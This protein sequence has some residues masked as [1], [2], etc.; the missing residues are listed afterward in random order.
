MGSRRQKRKLYLGKNYKKLTLRNYK[1]YYCYKIVTVITLNDNQESI[2]IIK[3]IL[4]SLFI[5]TGISQI[6]SMNNISYNLRNNENFLAQQK[7]WL[8]DNPI[9]CKKFEDGL[10]ELTQNNYRDILK[11]NLD[12]WA[13]SNSKKRKYQK[14]VKPQPK[15]KKDLKEQLQEWIGITPNALYLLSNALINNNLYQILRKM[16]RFNFSLD[17]I[18]KFNQIIIQLFSPKT[19]KNEDLKTFHESSLNGEV[20]I[21]RKFLQKGFRP[22]WLISPLLASGLTIAAVSKSREITEMFFECSKINHAATDIYGHTALM[23]SIIE[24]DEPVIRL[25]LQ[26]KD[27]WNIHQTNIFGQ[28]I[29]DLAKENI[30][31]LMHILTDYLEN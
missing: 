16:H 1:H 10:R 26:K 11:L 19:I 15:N 23:R 21:V 5:S 17:D 20:Q 30:P 29:F 22:N 4:T 8:T 9:E 31:H 28:T 24:K 13:I 2:M 27:L 25:L 12:Y 18:H 6:F 14:N 3:I 7:Q